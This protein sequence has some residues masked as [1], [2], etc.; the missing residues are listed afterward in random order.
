MDMQAL[1]TRIRQ[2]QLE[3]QQ[4]ELERKQEAMAEAL[5]K[6]TSGLQG[7]R[8]L[9]SKEL[10]PLV[11]MTHHKTVERWAREEGMP[12]VRKG[13]TVRFRLGDV[14]RWLEQRKG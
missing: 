4:R 2:H 3:K 10:A 8:L 11:G 9:T 1:V 12:C 13:R 5:S 14:L 6:R 7:E